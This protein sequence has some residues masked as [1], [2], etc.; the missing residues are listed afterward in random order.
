M[1]VGKAL[2]ICMAPGHRD[3]LQGL[4]LELSRLVTAEPVTE[5]ERGPCQQRLSQHAGSAV[6]T[7]AKGLGWREAALHEDGKWD[8]PETLSHSPMYGTRDRQA[9]PPLP[10]V[11]HPVARVAVSALGRGRGCLPGPS[12]VPGLRGEIGAGLEG[13]GAVSQMVPPGC[14]LLAHSEAWST[15]R[16]VPVHS[17]WTQSQ[18]FLPA[19]RARVPAPQRWH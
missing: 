14:G 3:Q 18:V 5:R 13:T 10:P 7:E 12:I 8:R 2:G 15:V 9:L 19:C 4:Q 1:S 16:S 6:E 11:L 17:C